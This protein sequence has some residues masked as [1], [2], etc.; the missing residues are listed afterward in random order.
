M[1]S[2]RRFK[3][4]IAYDGRPFEGW[5]SQ[6][7]GNTVQ[8]HLLAAARTIC[9]EISGIQ[10]SGRTD[11]GVHALGQV[12]HFDAPAG[13]RMDG[14]AWRAALNTKL[15]RTIRVMEC[16]EADLEFHAQFSAKQKTYRYR[17]FTGEILP[18]LE[19]GLA[20]QVRKALDPE[21]VIAAAKLFEGEH[22]FT[23]FSANRGDPKSEPDH[24]VRVVSKVSV[25]FRSDFIELTFTGNGFLYKMVRMLVGAIV[26]A[27]QGGGCFGRP[28]ENAGKPGFWGEIT[29]SGTG[30]WVISGF[31][32]LSGQL[33]VAAFVSLGW[34]LEL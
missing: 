23:A 25:S 13:N 14:R 33:E 2:T 17:V 27:G 20:W 30:R 26:K 22:D 34:G 9:G 29:V 1:K 21:K 3:L 16:E 4:T 15:P 18:P 5:Q 7:G 10:G 11:A 28:A 6:P 32:G 19:F 12:A 24:K 8:D 31:C